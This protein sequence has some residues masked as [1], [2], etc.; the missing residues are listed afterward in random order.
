MFVLNNDKITNLKECKCSKCD[1]TFY[2]WQ[3]L[4]FTKILSIPYIKCPYCGKRKYL[5][6]E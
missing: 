3:P 4:N 5:E 6:L 2:K 1:K